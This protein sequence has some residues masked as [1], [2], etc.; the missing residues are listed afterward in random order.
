MGV[1]KCRFILLLLCLA[2]AGCI[3]IQEPEFRGLSNLEVRNVGLSAVQIG[4]GMTYYNPNN[5]AVSV[6]ETAVKVYL[7]EVYLGE[8]AQDTVIAVNKKSEFTAPLSG[9][10]SMATFLKLDLQ[11]IHKREVSILAEGTTK[12]GKA[13][14]FITEKVHYEGRHRLSQ[15]RL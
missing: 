11:D 2:A 3:Q 1:K 14:F 8:F 7:D 5:F 10:I 4:F 15:F 12:V 13:G 6:K 9:Q